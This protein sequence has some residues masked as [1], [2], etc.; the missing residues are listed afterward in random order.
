MRNLIPTPMEVCLD[1]LARFLPCMGYVTSPLGLENGSICLTVSISSTFFASSSFMGGSLFTWYGEFAD[2]STEEAY[3]SSFWPDMMGG[4]ARTCAL[5]AF[6]FLLA[7]GA[8]LAE[9]GM[10]PLVSF[11]TLLRGLVAVTGLLPL[12]LL[13]SRHS[14]KFTPALIASFMICIGGYESVAAV[15]TYRPGL[16]FSTPYTLLIVLLFYLVVPLTLTHTMAAGIIASVMYIAALK[17][18]VVSGWANLFQLILFFTIV[19]ALGISIFI[20]MAG[21][22][23]RHFI[24]MEEIRSLNEKLHQ[25][26]RTKEETNRHLEHL[27]ITDS[28]T[29]VG[30]RRKFLEVADM[31][32]R[33]AYRYGV[34]F[35]VV[36]LDIDHFKEVNDRYG[37]E[38]GDIALCE[39]T[40]V[41]EEQLRCSD[42]LVRLGGE[43]FAILLPETR[44]EEAYTLAERVRQRLA[45]NVV[46]SGIIRFS[47]TAS[48]GVAEV[49][50]DREDSV[51]GILN[52]AD[53]ALY[54]AKAKGRNCTVLYEPEL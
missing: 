5:A 33:R 8:L 4:T 37:H 40:R 19:N 20:Q 35:S 3:R 41:V 2:R 52:R 12:V 23:R 1:R 11:L 43:E 38:G 6:G 10:T 53:S 32:R 14:A 54:K 47:I 26:V 46:R 49:L 31:E 34:P 24:D 7:G 39:L 18:F 28:L 9:Q 27:S 45:A 21:W 36:M 44:R 16:E 48:L 29:G 17:L 50:D 13:G 22:R 42:L 51:K 15:L 25:E 30:N